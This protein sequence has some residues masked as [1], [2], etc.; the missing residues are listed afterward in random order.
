MKPLYIFDLDGTIANVDHRLYILNSDD[1]DKWERFFNLCVFDEP[2]IPVITTLKHLRSSGA[3]IWIW[4]GRSDQVIQETKDWLWLLEDVVMDSA[5]L[6]EPYLKMRR[7]GY[8][9]SDHALKRKWFD[10]MSDEDRSRLVAVFEDRKK[11]VDMWRD[12]G[13]TCFQ[14]AADGAGQ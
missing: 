14:V 8:Y 13:V 10:A 5:H 1:D 11:V 4:T 12:A 2:I 6:K 3:D 7:E 9:K